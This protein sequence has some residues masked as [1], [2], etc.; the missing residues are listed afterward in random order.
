MNRGDNSS[1]PARR[2]QQPPRAPQQ[3]APQTQKGTKDCRRSSC[4]K[5]RLNNDTRGTQK[6]SATELK[7]VGKGKRAG[8]VV[9]SV[10]NDECPKS[11]SVQRKLSDD[12]NASE[13]YSKD[14]GCVS[15]KLSSSDSSSEMSDCTSEGNKPD[16][17]NIDPEISWSDGSASASAMHGGGRGDERESKDGNTV[18]NYLPDRGLSPGVAYVSENDSNLMMGETTEGLI[19]EVDEL[20]SENEYLK[21]RIC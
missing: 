7:S 12:S 8:S 14:S 11:A 1:K 5:T 10:S 13:D 20:R 3:G 19:R 17:Q 16:P 2:G 21:V 4:P 9:E 15:W 6:E 18:G